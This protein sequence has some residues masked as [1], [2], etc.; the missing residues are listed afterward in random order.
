MRVESLEQEMSVNAGRPNLPNGRS[1]SPGAGLPLQQGD[2]PN[3]VN[4]NLAAR[5][6]TGATAREFAK[7]ATKFAKATIEFAGTTIVLSCSLACAQFATKFAT[8]S[9]GVAIE[10]IIEELATLG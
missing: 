1:V 9:I 10:A 2:Q 4:A 3:G 7:A 5:K 6:P 8:A